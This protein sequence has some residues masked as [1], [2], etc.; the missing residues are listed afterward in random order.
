MF[1]YTLSVLAGFQ[2]RWPVLKTGLA[3]F[4]PTESGL[5]H[6]PAAIFTPHFHLFRSCS[7]AFSLKKNAS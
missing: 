4:Q 3:C 7:K 5:P 6:S 1:F 2:P